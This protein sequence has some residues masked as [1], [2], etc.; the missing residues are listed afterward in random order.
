VLDAGTASLIVSVAGVAVLLPLSLNLERFGVTL[1]VIGE[2]A[3]SA[4]VIKD[5]YGTKIKMKNNIFI[6]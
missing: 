6:L 2:I 5:F 4:L 3:S 1:I